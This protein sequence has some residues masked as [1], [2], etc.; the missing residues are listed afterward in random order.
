MVSSVKPPAEV[1]GGGR[2]VNPCFKGW[3]CG[4]VEKKSVS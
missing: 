2:K 1:I 3:I 4:G